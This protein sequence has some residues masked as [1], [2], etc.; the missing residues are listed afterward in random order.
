MP[1]QLQLRGGTTTE[2]NSFTGALREVT[3]DTTKKTLVVHDGS[4]AGGTPLM[5]ESGGTAATTVQI[6]TGGVERFKITNGE[7]VFNETSTDTDFRIEGDGKANLFK[8]DAGND[9]IGIGTSSPTDFLH[10]K[11]TTADVNL[12]LEATNTNKDA[13][14]KL[15]AHSTGLSQ[16]RMGDQND[17]DIGALT[18]D[19]SDNSMQ[20]RVNNSERTRIDSSGRLLIG[21]TVDNSFKF[22]LSDGGGFEFA[23][24][25]N[26]S[27]V[28]NF[29][30][31]DRANN[32]YVP[33][34]INASEHRFGISGTEKMRLDSSARLLLG[35]SA[36]PTGSGA[37]NVFGTTTEASSISIRRGS[38]D[39]SGPSISFQKSRNTTDGSHTVVQNDD[40]LGAIF[41]RGN[42]GQGPE[43]GAIIKGEVDGGAGGNDMPTRLVFGVT[44][45]GSDTSFELVKLRQDKTIE[46]GASGPSSRIDP[47]SNGSLTIEADPN[48]NFGSSIIR[49]KVDSHEVARMVAGTHR[50]FGLGRTSS[51][52]NAR[53]DI[54]NESDQ[55]VL[56]LTQN[57]NNQTT[58]NLVLLH[59]GASGGFAPQI[60]FMDNQGGI[61]GTI[62]NNTSST[63]YNTSSDYRLK[64]NEVEISDGIERI[65]QLK[66]Y[67]F[68]WKNRP[69]RIVDGFFAHEVQDIVEDCVDGTKD[70]VY[71][72]ANEDL[73]I[74]VG[75]PKYQEMDHSKLVPLLTAALKSLITR[76][77]ALEAA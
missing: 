46:L 22:K 48:S 69:D 44:P 27:G 73:K 55:D 32:V 14:V 5:R 11:D 67:R 60:V 3:V 41:F 29:T 40:L 65:K 53:M 66:P 50:F 16:L 30:N 35:T 28:N 31:F 76:V 52:S 4:Q 39:G 38:A 42:D 63:Q 24:L 61:R 25:P 8:V 34:L 21:T 62:K 49:F 77:E 13:R 20:F 12:L 9:R 37:I 19:H 47:S 10:L 1:D 70:E 72:E 59:T 51:Q 71:T 54:N 75:D 2:H 64:E 58:R 23:M 74:K 43:I 17:G 15:L 7:V 18:Y 26:D 57:T 56:F 6:G 68:N 45:D 33:L 36:T